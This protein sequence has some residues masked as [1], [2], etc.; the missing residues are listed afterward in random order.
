MALRIFAYFILLAIFVFQL[1]LAIP[2]PYANTIAPGSSTEV[3]WSQ[4]GFSR[5]NTNAITVVRLLLP[6]IIIALLAEVSVRMLRRTSTEHMKTIR[7][8]LE[9]DKFLLVCL[10]LAGVSF[11]SLVALI[12]VAVFLTLLGRWAYRGCAAPA[13]NYVLLV[14]PALCFVAINILLFYLYQMSFFQ[15]ASNVNVSQLF[16]MFQLVNCTS[17]SNST[18]QSLNLHL[19]VFDW[20]AWVHP[21]MVFLLFIALVSLFF[22]QSPFH[23]GLSFVA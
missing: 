5:F 22:S 10:L 4:V 2:G 13:T 11:P 1:V 23:T 17:P 12:Y 6:D 8:P 20:P 7:S 15:T 16:G 9:S 19:G 21:G 3:T 18:S 14:V